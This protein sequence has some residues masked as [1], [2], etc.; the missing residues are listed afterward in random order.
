MKF[1]KPSEISS[2]IMTLIDE[3]DEYVILVSPYVKISKWYKL[4]KK[5]EN[6][7]RRKIPFEFI[8]RDDNTNQASYEELTSLNVR[9]TSIPDLHCKLY[10]NE[11]YA[12]I[13]SM[14]LLLS[15][16]INSLEIAY[17]TE[18]EDE[19][20]E[21]LD[22]CNRYLNIDLDKLLNNKERPLKNFKDYITNNISNTLNCKISAKMD[23]NSLV[24]NTG[25]NNYNCFIC[26]EKKKN[27]LRISGV[28]SEKEFENIRNNPENRPDIESLN[29][30]LQQ[31][32]G[33][34]YSLIWGTTESS[35]ETVNLNSIF[36]KEEEHIA[37][38]I[39]NFVVAVDKFKKLAA[40]NS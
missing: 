11:K 13:S 9:F 39:I 7:K 28:L 14:N 21:L 2:K 26:N 31:G 32:N 23:E 16:E 12:I 37:D 10:I 1:I 8:I 17:I 27:L 25:I 20:T 38:M 3:S 4:L 40:H 6:L 36:E 22:F 18:K 15:S 33:K 29:I 19:H 5:I 30:N 34:Y 24:I 35:L